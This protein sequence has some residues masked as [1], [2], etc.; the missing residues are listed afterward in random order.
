MFTVGIES[1]DFIAD[2]LERIADDT[3]GSF[4]AATSPSALAEIYD[5]LGF[6]LSNEYLLRYRS[7]AQPDQDVD[8]A[9]AV[10]GAEPVSFSYTSPSTG[11]AAPYKP[12][13]R[14]ELL[15]SWL[16]IPLIVALVVGLAYFTI[17]ALLSLRTNKKL[18]ARLGE[19]VTLPEERAAE[20]RK[21]VDAPSGRRGHAEAA[22]TQ[23][24]VD[25]RVRRGRRR[26]P[27]QVRPDRMVWASVPP[28]SSS[29]SS[30]ALW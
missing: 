25:G 21:E 22:E 18:V 23:L 2:D 1:P 8:V 6:Q 3:G 9:V 28:V 7:A 26:R 10:A 24:A 16:L 15:Q 4:A 27:D 11:T 12:A 19:F 13:F 17:R 30:W 20:R 5:E 29:A 14:D